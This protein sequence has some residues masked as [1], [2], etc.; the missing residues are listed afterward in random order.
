MIEI[1]EDDVRAMR[2]EGSLGEF[3]RQQLAGAKARSERRRALVLGHEDL[4]QKL[5]EQPLRIPRPDLWDGSMPPE[6][7][8]GERNDSPRRPAL[9][10]LVAEAERREAAKRAAERLPRSA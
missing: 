7:F 3:I 5:T 4:A 2:K 6:M 10:A 1:H 9:L 8:N